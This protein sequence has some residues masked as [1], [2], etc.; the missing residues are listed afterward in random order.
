MFVP[1]AGLR[2]AA[3]RGF[4]VEGSEGLWM[5]DK[6]AGTLYPK[7]YSLSS[8]IVPPIGVTSSVEDLPRPLSPSALR[9]RSTADSLRLCVRPTQR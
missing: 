5:A 2:V 6:E 7:L 4:V 8:G 1:Y 9:L 3:V